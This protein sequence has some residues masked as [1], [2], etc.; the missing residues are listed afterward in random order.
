MG[1]GMARKIVVV[2]DEPDMRV[3]LSTLLETHGFKPI[4][5]M[6]GKEGLKLVR[7][8]KPS[9]ILLDVLMPKES[10]ITMYRQ[11]KSDPALKDIPVIM[12]SALSRKTFFHSQRVLDEYS[13][14]RIPEPAAY[15]EKPPEPEEL[16]DLIRKSIG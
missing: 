10:G 6:D 16:L 12:L 4:S 9:L 8:H 2:D 13:G 14:E 7:R 15:M 1:V 3:F 5:A 11:L